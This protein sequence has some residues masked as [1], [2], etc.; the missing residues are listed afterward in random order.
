MS[1]LTIGPWGSQ[2][3]SLVLGSDY[4][5]ITYTAEAQKYWNPVYHKNGIFT[6]KKMIV[7]HM[8]EKVLPPSAS[9]SLCRT[10]TR[11]KTTRTMWFLCPGCWIFTN[12]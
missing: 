9:L 2:L 4:N 11:T 1:A 6:T 12:R 7:D 5:H 8:T 10:T 3:T